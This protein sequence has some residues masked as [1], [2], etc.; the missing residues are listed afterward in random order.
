MVAVSADQGHDRCLELL[1]RHGADLSRPD[2]NRGWAAIHYCCRT[3]S[4]T[5]L[6]LLLDNGVDINT[7]TS[8]EDGDTA[9][10]LS[11]QNGHLLCLVCGFGDYLLI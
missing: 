6:A 9:A 4:Y 7:R 3:G 2:P 5:C 10:S 8:D 1:I 11:C